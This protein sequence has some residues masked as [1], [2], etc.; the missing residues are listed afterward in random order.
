MNKLIMGV[1]VTAATIFGTAAP[2]L[3]SH[4]HSK[5]VGNGSCVLLA[6]NGAE[7]DVQ[8]PFAQERGFTDPTRQHPLHVL[9]HLG[10]P[11]EHF[12]IAVA[13]TETDPCLPSGDYL[14]D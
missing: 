4:V 1:A 13:G 5:E 7:K 6:Q 10:Q 2:S 12:D 14:N 8:L 11:G 3:A 9:V